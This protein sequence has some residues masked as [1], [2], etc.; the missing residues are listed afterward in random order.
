M[1]LRLTATLWIF[2]F[3]RER[4]HRAKRENLDTGSFAWPFDSIELSLL[5]GV[6]NSFFSPYFLCKSPCQALIQYLKL[7]LVS[8]PASSPPVIGPSTLGISHPLV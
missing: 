7:L 1:D 5:P 8:L 4:E 2:L 3:L 6:I